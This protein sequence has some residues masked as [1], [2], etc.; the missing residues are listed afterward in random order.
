MQPR[1]PAAH[2]VKAGS[3]QEPEQYRLHPR[4]HSPP[5]GTQGDSVRMRARQPHA[6]RAVR[7]ADGCLRQDSSGRAHLRLRLGRQQAVE[8]RWQHFLDAVPVRQPH[9][10]RQRRLHK[11]PAGFARPQGQAR[12]SLKT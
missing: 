10:P 8:A 11:A 1:A 4:M 9:Q 6:S 3:A 5:D 12:R 7:R 2:T